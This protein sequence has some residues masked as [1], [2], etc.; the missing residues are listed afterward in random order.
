M[1]PSPEPSR[2][3][4]K[5]SLSVPAAGAGVFCFLLAAA[6]APAKPGPKSQ[7]HAATPPAK[8]VA[9]ACAIPSP[10]CKIATNGV[11]FP[12]PHPQASTASGKCEGT[13]GDL[14]DKCPADNFVGCCTGIPSGPDRYYY[15][16]LDKYNGV[17]ADEAKAAC[18][19]VKGKWAPK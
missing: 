3:S 18:A 8:P 16:V 6:S 7:P 5:S 1:P 13:G 10:G 2:F 4:S 17:T 11:C 15:S 12:A 19:A 9:G 14:T